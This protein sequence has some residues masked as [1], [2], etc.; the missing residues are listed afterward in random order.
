[1]VHQPFSD[2]TIEVIGENGCSDADD[3]TVFVDRR[4][5]VYVPNAFSPN[6]DGKNDRFRIFVKPGSVRSVHDFLVFDRWGE[7]VYEYHDF[8]PDEPAYGWDGTHRGD[9]MN[10]AVFVW[11]AIIEFVDGKTELFEG[12]VILVR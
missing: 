3:L 10:P 9:K 6:A 4:K 7:S 1:M 2:T 5:Q 8:D 12:D 11:F